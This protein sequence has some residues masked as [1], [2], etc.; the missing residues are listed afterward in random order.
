M[1]I[2]AAYWPGTLGGFHVLACLGDYAEADRVE[3]DRQA[4]DLVEPGAAGTRLGGLLGQPVAL[5]VDLPLEGRELHEA[6]RV[7]L[8]ARERP[9][10]SAVLRDRLRRRSPP[11]LE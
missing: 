1:A 10:A 6:Q 4:R 5:E 3:P 9:A 8:R 11:L 7:V 2:R